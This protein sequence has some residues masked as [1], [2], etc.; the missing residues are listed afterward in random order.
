M[1]TQFDQMDDNQDHGDKMV[2][3]SRSDIRKLEQAAQAAKTWENEVATL[4]RELAFRDAGINPS[5]PKLRYFVKGYDGE[6]TVDAIK[7]AAT[8]AGFL[9]GEQPSVTAGMMGGAMAQQPPPWQQGPS[10]EE[11]ARL[12]QANVVTS[13]TPATAPSMDAAYFTA[14][15]SAKS[16]ADVLSVMQR[17]GVPMPG[18]G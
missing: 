10:P 6:V 1:S 12:T 16:E 7:A 9:G 14:L 15:S 2:T 13:G 4:K 11:L 17:F 5:D 3:L 8:E 18:V